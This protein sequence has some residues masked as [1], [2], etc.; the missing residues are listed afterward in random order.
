MGNQKLKWTAEEEVALMAGVAKHGPGKWKNI[1]IDS[2][3]AHKLA[4]RSNVDLKDKWRN[5]GANYGQGSGDNAMTPKG[6]ATADSAVRPK[7][8]N[9]S[10]AVVSNDNVNEKLSQGPQNPKSVPKYNAMILEALSS[11]KDR[12]GSEFGAIM[13]FI[14]KKY[15]VQQSFRRL[16]SSK[17]RKLVLQGT[18]EKVQKRYKIRRAAS[19]SKTP[20][21]KQKGVNSRALQK[22]MLTISAETVEDAAKTAADK[23]AEAENKSFVAAE[24][25]KESE[26]VSRIAEDTDALLMHLKEGRT[27]EDNT[28]SNSSGVTVILVV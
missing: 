27:K 20:T 16:L 28:N 6:K 19:G 2:E 4:N 25:V 15:E 17:L 7:T 10:L 8:Q 21:P 18:L 26:R 23:I 9:S 24:A 1:I 22:S 14:E 13:R 12:N 3:F 5:L 11:L